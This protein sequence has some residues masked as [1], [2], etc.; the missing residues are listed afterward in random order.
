MKKIGT[1]ILAL[2]L[3][4]PTGAILA[5]E[6][7]QAVAPAAVQV[8]DTTVIDDKEKDLSPGFI[9]RAERL[10]ESL[11]EEHSLSFIPK[12]LC[13]YLL[14]QQHPNNGDESGVVTPG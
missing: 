1:L 5:E 10:C 9:K 3:L 6:T 8:D 13:F 14:N 7:S 2:I 11:M 4:A 12:T